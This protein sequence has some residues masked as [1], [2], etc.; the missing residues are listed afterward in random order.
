[1]GA[2]YMWMH[3]I[4]KLGGDLSYGDQVAEHRVVR[5]PRL[6]HAL[7]CEQ[8]IWARENQPAC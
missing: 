3:T 7:S 2:K 5:R 1:M 6:I 8:K 4:R